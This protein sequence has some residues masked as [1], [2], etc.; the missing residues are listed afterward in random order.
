VLTHLSRRYD[1]LTAPRF[2]SDAAAAYD[3]DIVL[4]AD[5]DVVPVP[6]R[7]AG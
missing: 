2:L 1:H 5:L 7:R 3:G 4:A 6:P